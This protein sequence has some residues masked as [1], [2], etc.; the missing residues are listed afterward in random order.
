MFGAPED[1]KE[2]EEEEEGRRAERLVLRRFL[3]EGR[4]RDWPVSLTQARAVI[5]RRPRRNSLTETV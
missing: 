4:G 5:A 3:V 2:E 1:E